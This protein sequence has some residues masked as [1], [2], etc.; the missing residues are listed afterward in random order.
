VYGVEVE[1]AAG[2]KI[3]FV[4]IALDR[5]WGRLVVVVKYSDSDVKF[6]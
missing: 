1:T 2:S 5:M 4:Y 6:E 3:N